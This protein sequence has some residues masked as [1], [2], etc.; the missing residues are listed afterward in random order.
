MHETVPR[1][2]KRLAYDSNG[3]TDIDGCMVPSLRNKHNLPGV[4]HTLEWHVLITERS[5]GALEPARGRF[6]LVVSTRRSPNTRGVKEPALPPVDDVIPCV[7]K[8]DEVR[9]ES[10]TIIGARRCI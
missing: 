7:L 8:K 2:S 4:L 10:Q 3:L 9:E 5:V 1:V 6:E